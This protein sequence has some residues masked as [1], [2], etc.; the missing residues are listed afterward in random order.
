MFTYKVISTNATYQIIEAEY[1]SITS[2]GFGANDAY[3]Y[4]TKT[5]KE[6]ELRS[7]SAAPAVTQ[8]ILVGYAH[9]PQVVQLADNFV[10]QP[11][12]NNGLT[13]PLTYPPGVR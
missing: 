2:D 12:G 11:P 6:R 5:V 1:F 3:F 10:Y 13:T 7:L 9:N 4:V 8:E